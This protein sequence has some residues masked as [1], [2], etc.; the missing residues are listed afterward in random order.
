MKKST[1]AVMATLVTGLAGQALADAPL[2]ESAPSAPRVLIAYYSWSGHTRLAAQQIQ[3]ATGGVLFEIRP[4]EAYPSAYRECT[5][6]AKREIEAGHRPKLQSMPGNLL[7][8]AD[9]VFVG[10]PNWWS[11]IA[12]P[13]ATFLASGDWTGK[14]VV[15]FVT[16]G[17][18][19]MAGC[20]EAM[21]KL[22]P[23]ATVLPGRAFPGGNIRN[24]GN[25]VAAWAQE[26]AT[27]AQQLKK[28]ERKNP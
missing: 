21:R 16:H 28:R 12:P 25:E 8:D 9:V 10:S 1:W 3:Q 26:V 14:T 27:S 17:G 4:V 5:E 18:G 11:T 6:Q 19:G 2:R 23:Q 20:A 22:C 13:V 15:P 24:L 7:E